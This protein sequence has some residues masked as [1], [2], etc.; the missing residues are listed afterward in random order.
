MECGLWSGVWDIDTAPVTPVL[1]AQMCP[2]F[3]HLI[4]CLL[5][6]KVTDDVEGVCHRGRNLISW[7]PS[8]MMAHGGAGGLPIALPDSRLSIT[9]VTH[10]NFNQMKWLL[11]LNWDNYLLRRRHLKDKMQVDARCIVRSAAARYHTYYLAFR[12]VQVQVIVQYGIQQYWI[13][14]LTRHSTFACH[15]SIVCRTYLTM[16]QVWQASDSWY[17]KVDC[18]IGVGIQY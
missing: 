4:S 9:G 14:T 8:K 16:C 10:F 7:M 3:S 5:Y 12:I 17:A 2:V 18:R 1:A 13:P 6:H 11:G 15:E